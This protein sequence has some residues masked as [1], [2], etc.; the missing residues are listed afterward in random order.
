MRYHD[1]HLRGYRVSD[2]GR[3]ITLDLVYDYSG[4]PKEESQI[5]FTDVALYNFIHTGG[6][7]VMDIDE[8]SLSDLLG[9]VGPS[10]IVW[11]SDQGVTGWRDKLDSYRKGLLSSGHRAWRVVSAIGFSGFMVA[12]SVHQVAPNTSPERTREE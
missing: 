12:R 10:L 11:N 8:T 5:E 1:F 4:R 6:A 7:I 3:R 2:F 9:E